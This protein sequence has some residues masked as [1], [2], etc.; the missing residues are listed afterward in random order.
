MRFLGKNGVT[1]LIIEGLLPV[2]FPIRIDFRQQFIP[3]PPCRRRHFLF[4]FLVQICAG[5]DMGSVYKHCRQRQRPCCSSLI[6]H[7]LE[8][9]FCRP[10]CEPM[11]EVIAHRGEMRQ[12][13]V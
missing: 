13:L 10:L 6:Q 7:P 4:D 8:Y 3:I 12:C 2:G 9:F 11:A 5:L 1:V